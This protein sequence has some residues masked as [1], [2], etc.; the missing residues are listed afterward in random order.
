MQ[1]IHQLIGG[2]GTGKTT[3]N[4][5]SISDLCDS[6]VDPMQILFSSFTRAARLTAARRA[7]SITGI[8]TDDL[9]GSGWFKTLQGVCY[10]CIGAKAKQ[11]LTDDKASKEW[12]GALFGVEIGAEDDFGDSS[13]GKVLQEWAVARLRL[14]TTKDPAWPVVSMDL[15]ES[16]EI[17]EKYE[18]KKYTDGKLDFVDLAMKFVGIVNEI[19]GIKVVEPEG[20]LP[21]VRACI[22]DEYQ[23][24]SFLLHLVAIRIAGGPDVESVVVSGDPFQC[25]PAGTP[26]LTKNGY[27]A[28]EDLDPDCDGL[29]AYD[30]K[31]GRVTG[32]GIGAKFEK[33]CRDVDSGDL[34]EITFSD[35]TKSVCT[36]NHKWL[37]RTKRQEVYATYLMKKGIRWRVGTVQLFSKNATKRTIDKNGQFRFKMRMNQEGAEEGWLLRTFNTDREARMQEQVLSCRYGIPQVTFRPPWVETNLDREFIDTIFESLGDLTQN[38]MTCLHDHKLEHNHPYSAK[39]DRAKNGEFACRFLCAAN[40]IP[41]LHAVPKL[42]PDEKKKMTASSMSWV[43][44]VSVRHLDPGKT[45]R[46]YSLEVEKHHTYVTTNG[47]VTGNSIYKY[48]GSEHSYLMNGWAYTSKEIMR[49]SYR[50]TQEILNFGESIIQPCE[51]YFDREITSEKVGSKVIHYTHRGRWTPD[52]LDDWLVI[53]RTNHTVSK[54]TKWLTDKNVPWVSTDGTENGY[55]GPR[56]RRVGEIFHRIKTG[57]K[58]TGGEWG[59]A[60]DDIPVSYGKIPFL[61]RGTKS[62]AK[63]NKWVRSCE[64]MPIDLL[65]TGATP[66][67]L[68]AIETSDW[69]MFDPAFKKFSSAV[70]DYGVEVATN[71]KIRAGTIHSVKGDEAE[72]VILYN[73]QSSIIREAN[74]GDSQGQDE[75]R[76]VWYVGATRAKENLIVFSFEHE[77]D[78]YL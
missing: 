15:K 2:A 69:S 55:I 78:G 42:N 66:Q 39:S 38:G 30:R 60:I 14:L 40:I 29:I 3:Q 11:M 9:I 19:H 59:Y 12:M 34:M 54:M 48:I 25:Q 73:R 50:C 10:R 74:R 49:K 46:V 56:K 77:K 23:D 24:T 17:I 45:V 4:M 8:P 7:E 58:I 20:E 75:E 27:K 32:F 68:E 63:S 52:P 35:G 64:Y 72:N 44:I 62:A 33:A 57:R 43:D 16:I 51:D 1:S 13:T 41:G 6:G 28:I 67:L 5:M 70:A 18:R 21:D 53:G 71:P 36:R 65:D 22:F 61:V 47:I 26:V 76:R 37:V 31:W